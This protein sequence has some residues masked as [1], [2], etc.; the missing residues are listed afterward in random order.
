MVITTYRQLDVWQIAIE[1]VET[2]Y[3]LTREFPA[4]ERFGL[5]SQL[6]RAAVSIPLNIAEGWGR[7][8]R[9]DYLHH[10]SI[11]RG[12]LMEVETCLIIAVRVGMTDKE[13]A[14]KV[15]ELAQRVGQM[16][17]ATISSMQ[18]G[19]KQPRNAKRETRTPKPDMIAEPVPEYVIDDFDRYI[20]GSF[21]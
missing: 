14:R 5:T 1:L 10:L 19:G 9:G 12:S 15:W 20:S 21:V 2:A 17:T 7:S 4:D 11:A 6:Q 3:I 13:S 16:L 8:H 18:S